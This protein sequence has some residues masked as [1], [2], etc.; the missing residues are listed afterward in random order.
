MSN[1]QNGKIYCLR[2]HQTDKIYIGS[3]IQK[4]YRRM[5]SHKNTYKNGLDNTTSKEILCYDDCYIELL[6]NYP[7]NSKEELHKREGEL[8]KQM[9]CV[10][11]MTAGRKWKEYY[12]DNCEKI[13]Q[14]QKDYRLKNKEKVINK[15]KE[16]KLC[17]CGIYY[18]YRNKA[19]HEKSKKHLN[20]IDNN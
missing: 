3:T 11:I 7:C 6:E 13:K 18:T 5:N 1:Y 15:L 10:N 4:L 14:Y 12:E 2:S 16:K 9:D 8:I 20:H 19:R 17:N